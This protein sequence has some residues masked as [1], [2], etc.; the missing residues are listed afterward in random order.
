MTLMATYYK[1]ETF[2]K[3]TKERTSVLCEIRLSLHRRRQILFTEVSVHTICLQNSTAAVV[4]LK[5]P[6]TYCVISFVWLHRYS[7]PLKLY[8]RTQKLF[9]L[10]YL[11]PFE[12][13]TCYSV[14]LVS[15]AERERSCYNLVTFPH[16]SFLLYC[17][18][19]THTEREGYM[20][21]SS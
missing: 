21:I 5:Y 9:T 18:H 17:C 8:A 4:A 12:V 3:T 14:R 11:L 10:V 1:F 19:S 15:F 13:H 6:N 2:K 7:Y 16:C 20:V